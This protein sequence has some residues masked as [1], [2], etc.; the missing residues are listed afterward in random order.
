[1]RSYQWQ[2]R[3]Q[4]KLK[5]G[6]KFNVIAEQPFDNLIVNAFDLQSNAD[7]DELKQSLHASHCVNLLMLIMLVH[8]ILQGQTNRDSETA[9]ALVSFLCL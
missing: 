8:N 4:K 5:I 3:V 6:S 9:E 2:W 1:M 7:C